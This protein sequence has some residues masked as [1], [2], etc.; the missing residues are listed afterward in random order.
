MT[1][2]ICLIFSTDLILI[3][4]LS[5]MDDLHETRNYILSELSDPKIG[6][7]RRWDMQAA[8]RFI[9]KEIADEVR[10]GRTAGFTKHNQ[11]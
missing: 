2:R 9:E 10:L 1:K 4:R 7:F 11:I 5:V 8:L 6:F 3:H